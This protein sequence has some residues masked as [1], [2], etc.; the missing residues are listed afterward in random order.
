MAKPRTKGSTAKYKKPTYRA[1]RVCQTIYQDPK[2]GRF[3][4]KPKVRRKKR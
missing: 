1:K 3:I 4:K 2:T